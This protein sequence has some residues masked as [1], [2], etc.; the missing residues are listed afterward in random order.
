MFK[1]FF[2]SSKRFNM[3]T[4]ANLNSVVRFLRSKDSDRY[5]SNK[6]GINYYVYCLCQVI[7]CWWFKLSVTGIKLF[8]LR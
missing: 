6:L 5:Y 1:A 8:V 2:C 3:S 4:K 7:A